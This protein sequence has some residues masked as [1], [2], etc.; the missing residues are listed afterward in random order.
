MRTA[1]PESFNVLLPTVRGIDRE[2]GVNATSGRASHGASLFRLAHA[3]K[4]LGDWTRA[5]TSANAADGNRGNLSETQDDTAEPRT[6]GFPLF[7]TG[8]AN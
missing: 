4:T 7:I 6:Q 2:P 3:V 1:R 5:Y 8:F